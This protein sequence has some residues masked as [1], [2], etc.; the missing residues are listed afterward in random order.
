MG[1]QQSLGLHRPCEPSPLSKTSIP[2]GYELSSFCLFSIPCVRSRELL[3]SFLKI[4]GSGGF[5][6]RENSHEATIEI[7]C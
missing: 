1:C 7:A 4:L 5:S 6:P 3:L 2:L